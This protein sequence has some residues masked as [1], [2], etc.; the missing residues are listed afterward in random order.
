[1]VVGSSHLGRKVPGTPTDRRYT[2]TVWR[3]DHRARWS[4]TTLFA[5]SPFAF[6]KSSVRLADVTGD[7]HRDLL[8][9]IECSDCNHAVSTTAVYADVGGSMRRIYG[10]GFLDG[11]KGR[12]IGVPGRAIFETAWGAWKGMIWFDE[13]WYGRRSSLCCPE[14]RVQTFLRWDGTR[15]R[16]VRRRKAP[17]PDN[18]LG[19]RP[20][21]AP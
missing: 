13:P 3:R 6:Q 8:V 18:F 19:Q 2:L 14:Y 16:T 15:W 9:T 5:D 11:S 20:V 21:P 1:M 4:H 17:E 10:K 12:G 7:G